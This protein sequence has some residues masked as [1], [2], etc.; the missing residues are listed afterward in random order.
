MTPNRFDRQG[1]V[2]ARLALCP[3]TTSMPPFHNTAAVFFIYSINTMTPPRNI[4]SAAALVTILLL[5]FASHTVRSDTIKLL[6]GNC[7]VEEYAGI[8]NC[9]SAGSGFTFDQNKAERCPQRGRD[10]DPLEWTDE[11]WQCHMYCSNPE[12]SEERKACTNCEEVNVSYS[13]FDAQ[14]VVCDQFKLTADNAT[15]D[16]DSASVPSVFLGG[17]LVFASFYLLI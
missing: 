16:C 13:C 4:S 17:L 8:G 2:G 12:R 5:G 11:K 1:V 14:A 7:T 6:P 3:E 15:V 9:V 10:D